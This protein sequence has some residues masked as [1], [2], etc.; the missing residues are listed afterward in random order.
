MGLG[1][2]Y[3]RVP[4]RHREEAPPVVA[5][6]SATHALQSVAEA[7]GGSPRNR[8]NRG[9]D[10]G[11]GFGGRPHRGTTIVAWRAHSPSTPAQARR[12]G[13]SGVDR[14]ACLKQRGAVIRACHF[15][16]RTLNEALK[17]PGSPALDRCGSKF[18]AASAYESR[19]NRRIQSR[20]AHELRAGRVVSRGR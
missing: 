14:S 4:G 18:G 2:R 8:P 10:F 9:P 11:P 6:S 1:S 7:V 3:L 20:R 16:E 13:A 12:Y 17:P 15:P 19:L 5:S